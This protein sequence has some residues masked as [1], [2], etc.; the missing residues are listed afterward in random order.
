MFLLGKGMD[1]FDMNLEPR[2]GK[3]EGDG[4]LLEGEVNTDQRT[5]AQ[6]MQCEGKGSEH[7]WEATKQNKIPFFT[8]SP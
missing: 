5:T 2:R 1:R 4:H 6:E 8:V 3:E 7:C